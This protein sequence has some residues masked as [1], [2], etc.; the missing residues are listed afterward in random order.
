MPDKI[1]DPARLQQAA[2]PG[3]AIERT[4]D[5]RFAEGMI[6]EGRGLANKLFNATRLVLLN[7]DPDA[8]RRRYANN[9]QRPPFRRDARRRPSAASRAIIVCGREERDAAATTAARGRSDRHA[10]GDAP[11]CERAPPSCSE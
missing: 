6:D 1:V 10:S 8:R 9:A 7:A 3:E 11:R 2:Q 5:V 4:Q